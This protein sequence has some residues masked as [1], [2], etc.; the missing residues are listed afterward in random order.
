[1]QKIKICL[2]VGGT[3]IKGTIFSEYNIEL[4]GGINYY[5]SKSSE[6][7]DEVIDNFVFI[8]TD[9]LSQ[10]Y[11][12][13]FIIECVKMAFP[14]PFDYVNGISFIKDLNKY[15]NIYEKDF[16]GLFEA[17]IRKSKLPI[18]NN[19]YTFFE[20][21]ATSFAFGE[22]CFES[23]NPPQKGAY[24]TLGTGCGSTFI[25]EDQQ[26][27]GEYGIPESG[28]IYNKSF[29]DG[30]I[31]EYLSSRMLEKLIAD[32]YI[33]PI[34]VKELYDQATE[35]VED[36]IIVFE[37]FGE[38]IGEALCPIIYEFDPDQIVFGGQI[39]KSLEFMIEG[40]RRKFKDENKE[41][42]IRK[43]RDTS[44]ST[45]MGLLFAQNKNLNIMERIK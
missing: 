24:F 30:I 18:S 35:S 9:L 2:D 7:C 33:Q 39:S 19:Y 12:E 16:R 21:D 25:E 4:L 1:M 14:G 27:F 42:P 13:D 11:N 41:I 44:Y 38:L 15:E 40:I 23:E 28:M 17:A 3:F 8:V 37:K 26:V 43:S 10:F 31:D 22:H 34:S 32:I 36:A 5:E 45:V 6:S 29:R 20:N